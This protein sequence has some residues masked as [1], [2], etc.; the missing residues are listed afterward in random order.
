MPPDFAIQQ[1]SIRETSVAGLNG[2]IPLLRRKQR[3][4]L[5]FERISSVPHYHRRECPKAE[6]RSGPRHGFSVCFRPFHVWTR[7]QC[8]LRAI[9]ATAL[10]SA[11]CV[12]TGGGDARPERALSSGFPVS[13]AR[14]IF[15]TI[16]P[17]GEYT[18]F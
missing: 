4:M 6:S 2:E 5:K 9:R 14:T 11:N 7:I 10:E 18:T 17:T 3:L 15:F 16:R 13:H 1:R 12:G 8:A